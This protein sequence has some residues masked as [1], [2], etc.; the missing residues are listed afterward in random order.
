MPGEVVGPIEEDDN[1]GLFHQYVM[2]TNSSQECY[3]L[4]VEVYPDAKGVTWTST[5]RRCFAEFS[6]AKIA[7]KNCRKCEACIFT[8]TDDLLAG[9]IHP[10][11]KLA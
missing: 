11:Y 1:N 10:I 4:V 8:R 2:E 3:K 7:T 5:Y 6:P 9:N